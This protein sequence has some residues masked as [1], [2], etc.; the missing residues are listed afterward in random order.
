MYQSLI[1]TRYAKALFLKAK[2]EEILDQIMEDICFVQSVFTEHPDILITLN[3]PVTY[4]SHKVNILKGL[5][6][7]KV[8]PI[9]LDFLLLIA[10]NHRD[11]YFENIFRNF[12]D[13]Y[14]E[15][16]GIKTVELT[17][18]VPIGGDEREDIKNYIREAFHANNITF[19]EKVNPELIGGFV[20]QIEDKLL[21]VS[22]KTQLD[23][24]RDNL[25]H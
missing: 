1:S 23:Q 16:K 5:F 2:E 8:H 24:I 22:V 13:F 18:A 6:Q 10:K 19:T 20:I 25:T 7:D 14:N 12:I 3:H 9:I 21:D 15:D 17:T 11:S 4:S